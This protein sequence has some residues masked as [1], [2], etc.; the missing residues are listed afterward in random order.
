METEGWPPLGNGC[1]SPPWVARYE[2]G[3]NADWEVA[4]DESNLRLI[5]LHSFE[6]INSFPDQVQT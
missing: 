5:G 2:G 1:T 3:K 6:K 4:P